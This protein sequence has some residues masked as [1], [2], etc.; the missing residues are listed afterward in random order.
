MTDRS[1]D[2]VAKRLPSL[3]GVR[4]FAAF[5]VFSCHALVL[6][7]FHPDVQGRLNDEAFGLGWLGVEFF[8]VL[9]GFVLAWSFR[10]GR[11][12]TAFWRRRLVK[13]YPNHVVT[14]LAALGLAYWAGR[15][16]DLPNL[17]PNLFLVHTWLPRADFIITI[18][19]VTWSLACEVFF[20]LAF[21]LLYALVRRIPDHLLWATAAGVA[22][23]ILV[24]P[25]VAHLWLPGEP[26]LPGQDMSLTQNWFLVS[27][28]PVRAL[29]F[30]LGILAARIVRAG[31]WIPLP[32]PAALALLVA[33]FA[34][35]VKLWPNVY[36]L[37]ATVVVPI[38]LLIPA[39]AA[40]D[41]AGKASVLRSRPLIF[42]GE[43]SFASYL[44]HFLVLSFA[45]EPLGA[46][47]S[48]AAPV[49]IALVAVLFGITTLLSWGLHRLVEVPAMRRWSRAVPAAPAAPVTPAPPAPV[50]PVPPA[51]VADPA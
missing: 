47:R 2:P 24:L 11:P 48:W 17:L 46:T 19:V 5:A 44:V 30:T 22:A 28:P 32:V 26:R 16:V 51:P 3:T 10:E 37:T 7:Y 40:R 21:P 38:A 49:A 50:T 35:Q 45:H 23:V 33:G 6:G 36:G 42:L 41:I 27:F 34:A 12:P 14:W 25:A 29:D 13:I 20:Y 1:A 18:N 4:F 39:I 31:R 43:I 9:S 8:F 15:A